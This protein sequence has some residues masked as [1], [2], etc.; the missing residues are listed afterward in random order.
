MF[1]LRTNI[2][3]EVIYF[4]TLVWAQQKTPISHLVGWRDNPL[5]LSIVQAQ[6]VGLVYFTV[7]NF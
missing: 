3:Y 1:F 2:I 4:E 6:L 5:A 7:G